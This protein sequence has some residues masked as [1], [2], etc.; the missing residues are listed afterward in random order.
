MKLRKLILLPACVFIFT[1]CKQEVKQSGGN[2]FQLMK[3]TTTDR[4]LSVKYSTI[5]QGRQDV[6]I[7]PQVGGTIT[8]VLVQEGAEVRKGQVLFVI[9]PIPYEAALQAAQAA[10]ETAAANV[11]TAELNFEGKQLLYEEHVISDFEL[12]TSK[13]ELRSAKAMLA[14]AKAQEADARNS[15]SYTKVKSPVDGVAGMTSYRVGALVS[16]SIAE[17]LV[18]VSDNSVVYAYFSMSEKQ[19]LALIREYASLQGAKESMANVSLQLSDGSLCAVQG[20][21]DV[22]SGIVDRHTGTVSLRAAFDN[23]DGR[24]MS[25]SSAN[26]VMPYV[27][28]NCI[29]IP[30]GATFEMQDKIYAYKVVDGV[31]QSTPISV[32]PI[33]NGTEYIVENGLEVGDVIVAEGAGLLKSGTVVTSKGGE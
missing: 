18:S 33:N 1:A 32:F 19:V 3:L 28:E 13:N 17:P 22:I 12:R 23:K 31:A 15:L 9:D 16:S 21:I 8:Q 27:K 14:Q 29:V 7:R 6:E 10:V 5:L 24:L 4:T 20:K 2:E 30:Q 11:A 25:G 26:I